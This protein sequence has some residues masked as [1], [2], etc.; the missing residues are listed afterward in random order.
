MRLGL[1]LGSGGARGWA[2]VGVLLALRDLGI[3]PDVV[4]G[5]SMGA[6]IG[7]AWA[8]DCLDEMEDWARA[9]TRA[10]ILAKMDFSFS[11][12]GLMRGSVVMQVLSDL[13]VPDTFEKLKYPLIVVA[14]DMTSGR[15]VW[16]QNGSV[17][18]AVRGSVSIPGVLSP[19]WH[20]GKWLLDG[21]LTNPVPTSACRALGADVTIA[22]NPNAKPENAL[23][24]QP[25]TG[26][27]FWE[28]FSRNS[29]MTHIV[30]PLQDMLGNDEAATGRPPLSPNYAEVVSVSIDIMTEFV[31]KTRA[32]TDPAHLTL[33]MELGQ[34]SL[35]EMHRAGEAIDEGRRMVSDNRDA[36]LALC[37]AD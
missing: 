19:Y 15:E 34:I 37:D 23:W 36:I 2:H 3:R 25:Q 22:V 17:H 1:A 24:R 21:G 30:S 4:A 20:D 7:A 9:Q 32:A 5:T 18:H 6:L 8:A 16:L 11:G 14:T 33:S 27:S 12:G 26:E 28:Q 31:R 29:V 10:D 13:G 35:M